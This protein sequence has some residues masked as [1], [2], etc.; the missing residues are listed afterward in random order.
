MGIARALSTLGCLERLTDVEDN[1]DNRVQLR[2]SVS[3][4]GLE[5]EVALRYVTETGFQRFPGA[6]IAS[7]SSFLSGSQL[8]A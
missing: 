1:P 4:P 6:V 2:N 5:E 7:G 8:H 3:T